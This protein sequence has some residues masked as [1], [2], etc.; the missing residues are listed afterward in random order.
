MIFRRAGLLLEGSGCIVCNQNT[1]PIGSYGPLKTKVVGP[2]TNDCSIADMSDVLGV[3]HETS[4]DV[5]GLVSCLGCLGYLWMLHG[6]RDN[7]VT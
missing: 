5:G 3:L 6:G 2:I 7:R 1:H 4:R